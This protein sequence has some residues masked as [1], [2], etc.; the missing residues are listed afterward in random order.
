MQQYPAPKLLASHE[1]PIDLVSIIEAAAERIRVV[2]TTFRA[3]DPR[4]QA[5]VEALR[6][7]AKRGVDVSVAV[8]TFSYLEPKEFILRSPRRQPA[9]AFR[10]LQIEH[11]LKRAGAEFHWLGRR[12]NI[13]ATGRT[14]SKWVVV[15]DTVY[16]F[17]GVNLDNESFENTDYIIKYQSRELAELIV[18]EHESIIAADRNGGG[19]RSHDEVL[20]EQTTVLFDGGLPFDSIIYRR[21]VT[22]A[23]QAS[24]II[25]VSQYCPTG[26]LNRILKQKGAAIYF[27]HWRRA[28]HLN[29]LLIRLGMF[30]AQ[31]TTSYTRDNYLHAKFIIFTMP[32]GSKTAI[33]GS[34]NFMFS[35]GLSGTREIAIQTTNR[36]II[37]QLERYRKQYVE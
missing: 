16:S 6:A 5:V 8:D 21:A 1:Y 28:S 24:E 3:D 23:K 15:D 10:A 32:G 22:L 31:Q 35:S 17:G 25:L 4:S 34:H 30:T 27:N 7:A 19:R 14:H 18:T 2:S 29:R 13:L 37:K 20:N 33:A 11:Q 36:H 12:T 9:R 26:R